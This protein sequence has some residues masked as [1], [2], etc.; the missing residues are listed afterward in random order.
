MGSYANFII[1]VSS[2]VDNRVPGAPP[3]AMPLL[4]S[5]FSLGFS[6]CATSFYK[7]PHSVA[8]ILLFFYFVNTILL[9]VT[10]S[11]KLSEKKNS[12]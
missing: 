7:C 3:I 8:E 9:K 6:V 5:T 2:Y 1:L 10:V 12:S 4:C 11:G